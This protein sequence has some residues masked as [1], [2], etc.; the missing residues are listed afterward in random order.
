VGKK[1]KRGFA[2]MSAEKVAEI[3]G[4]GGKAAHALGRAH[5]FTSDE[6]K[7]AGA[8]G[9]KKVSR[10][11]AHMAEIGRLGGRARAKRIK[12]RGRDHV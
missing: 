8:S 12:E 2:S 5:E 9:G 1:S 7:I 11:R 4:S 10:D 6:A 3:A